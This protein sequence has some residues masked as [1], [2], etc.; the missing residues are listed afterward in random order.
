LRLAVVSP[1][2]DRQHGTESCVIEQIERLSSEQGWEIHLYSQRVED[3]RGLGTVS[4]SHE[5]IPSSIIWHKVSGI[6]GPHLF[7][8]LWWYLAN[9]RTRR[10]DRHS[11]AVRADLT[12]SPGIN[13]PDANVIVVHIVFHEF[14]ARVKSEL[15][16]RNVS[17]PSWP[18]ILHRRL[19]YR[20]IMGLEKK[21]YGNPD[22]R[23]IAVSEL[24][25]QQLQRYF[26]RADVTVIP[27]AVDTQ[28]FSPDARNA[29]RGES[30]AKSQFSESDFV[31]LLIGNDWRKKGLDTL[32][33]AMGELRDLPLQLLVV[34][35]DD[36]ALY[37]DLVQTPGLTAR[38]RFVK[39]SPDV[40]QF[41]AAADLYAGPSLED[42]FN[43]PILEAMA[44]GLS[45]IASVNA[46]ASEI[47]RDGETGLLLR[48]PHKHEDLAWLLRFACT[49]P[50]ARE[51]IGTAAAA[52][53]RE[54]CSWDRNA[55]LTR[56]TLEEALAR[57]RGGFE[58][59]AG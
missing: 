22:I 37:R 28:K 1:F 56:R 15:S 51:R 35:K 52:Y 4:D 48:D 9:Q 3:V 20:L 59:Q 50:L 19:Y 14:H 26:H 30:R 23:L 53:V 54:H 44:C 24:V 18:L 21:I 10:R 5:R 13:C 34:G 38:V 36:P 32:L 46:G 31:I 57:R 58:S 11:G 12:Y 29:R 40:L 2:L 27:N 49:D 6:P 47:I 25:A 42:A 45:V 16:L 33:R 39:P 55:D 17:F 41:Y 8:Y 43:L 7:Q